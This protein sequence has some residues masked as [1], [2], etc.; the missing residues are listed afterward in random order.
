MQALQAEGEKVSERVIRKVCSW[1]SFAGTWRRASIIRI[2]QSPG[3][4][5][6]NHPSSAFTR[7]EER[8]IL[9]LQKSIQ[10]N[11]CPLISVAKKI[12]I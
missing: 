11:L 5:K 7:T 10:I 8:I 9:L 1:P 6:E 12:N 3:R 4:Q 2:S